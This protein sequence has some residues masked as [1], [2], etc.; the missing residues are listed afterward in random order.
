MPQWNPHF[1][2]GHGV[3]DAERRE[4]DLALAPLTHAGTP[5]SL[6]LEVHRG[7]AAW[8]IRHIFRVD[9]ALRA[10]PAPNHP[11]QVPPAGIPVP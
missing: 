10:R 2:T 6:L 3:I 8:I 11:A 4:L 9:C 7:S 5:V 1:E